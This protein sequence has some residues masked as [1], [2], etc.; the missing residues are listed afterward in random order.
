MTTEPGS[1]RSWAARRRTATNSITRPGAREVAG[2]GWPHPATCGTVV[3]TVK[4]VLLDTDGLQPP[5]SWRGPRPRARRSRRTGLGE[6]TANIGAYFT[7][8]AAQA[9]PSDCIPVPSYPWH[10]GLHVTEQAKAA[11]SGHYGSSQVP[12]PGHRATRPWSSD[13]QR[14]RSAL[15]SGGPFSTMP[16]SPST[17]A[18]P[19]S[20]SGKE[21]VVVLEEVDILGLY[22]NAYFS[23][24]E[25]IKRFYPVWYWD[26]L[27]MD[28]IWR[29]QGK[30]LDQVRGGRT[31]ADFQQQCRRRMTRPVATALEDPSA[32]SPTPTGR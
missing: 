12:G 17:G 22:D 6:G 7:A 13:F 1:K 24:Y 14:G 15:R 10:P 2:V 21:Q 29:A 26:V 28:C 20:R 9:V 11:Y 25:E 3:N 19:T 32:W 31:A 27:E 23:V 8:I 30:Q 5:R 16:D 4:G 18:R